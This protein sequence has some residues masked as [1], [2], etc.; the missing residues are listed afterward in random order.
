MTGKLMARLFLATLLFLVLHESV[1]AATIKRD[2]TRIPVRVDDSPVVDVKA[3]GAR[4]DGS[5][6][7]TRGIAAALAAAARVRGS[8]LRF[9]N[10]AGPC[11]SG[12]F[13]VPAGV[14]VRFDEGAL[15]SL[16]KGALA[17]FGGPIEAGPSEHFTGA[18]RV[19]FAGNKLVREAYL[20][21]W[22][23]NND[24]KTDDA[25]NLQKVASAM[26]SGMSLTWPARTN[27]LI[28]GKVTFAH[29]KN[30]RM[31][32][33]NKVG[34]DTVNA[35]KITLG[36]AG[37]IIWDC[38]RK[39]SF[40][41]L[42]VLSTGNTYALQ[43]DQ[44]TSTGGGDLSSDNTIEGNN[45]TTIAGNADYVALRI[46]NASSANNEF[47][48]ILNNT[49]RGRTQ[50]YGSR[51]GTGIY[52][53]HSNVKNVVIETNIFAGLSRSINS[54]SASFRAKTNRHSGV[55]VCYYGAFSDA[56]LIAGDDAEGVSQVLDA[57]GFGTVP[58]LLMGGRYNDIYGGASSN[59]PSATTAPVFNVQ[60][61]LYL[62]VMSCQFAPVGGNAFGPNFI[63]DAVGNN[64]PLMW[65]NNFVV[66]I[67]AEN[68]ALALSSFRSANGF[69]A[70][71]AQAGSIAWPELDTI[72]STGIQ[73]PMMRVYADRVQVGAGEISLLGLATPA[74]FA[75]AQV[76]ATG[77]T[78]RLFRIV[79]RDAEGNR[80]PDSNEYNLTNS[81]AALSVS[82]YV[83]T[84]WSPVPGASGYDLIERDLRT[85]LFRLVAALY[86]KS[87]GGASNTSPIVITAPA[88]GLHTG[89]QVYISGVAGNASANNSAANPRWSVTVTSADAFSLDASS[90][91]GAY[92]GGGTVNP[93]SYRITANPAGPLTYALPI[94]N[95]TGGAQINGPVVQGIVVTFADG[96]TT[97]SVARSSDFRTANAAPTLI[98]NFSGGRDGQMIT[99][100]MDANT[101]IQNNGS[102]KTRSGSNIVGAVNTTHSFKRFGGVWYQVD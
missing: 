21:W 24:G 8:V 81:N 101:S 7:D 86:V 59:G 71:P 16:N 68:L 43:L 1:A 82:N 90:G 96:A 11:V 78:Q 84:T 3:Y 15:L 89:D 70:S 54:S 76:G 51:T 62:S 55:D 63:R 32:G 85:G 52:L 48:Q 12:S 44:L 17:S 65:Q 61:S 53:G 42:F 87:I 4:C 10:T 5:A 99:I 45:F 66:G 19:S 72:L 47:H 98:T 57:Q 100:L 31:G 14:T 58:V 49:F 80:T 60:N 9:S 30:F 50:T 26:E 35:A 95:E 40:E 88:H 38:V 18:G 20:N 75:A 77:T 92:L 64:M 74:N 91:S 37:T 102:I 22:Q 69:S 94:Y 83:Q 28:N 34:D 6:D 73:R 29:L 46:A 67:T 23:L 33:P 36:P 79:A 39:S 27:L 25:A 56:V 41:N 13:S 93:A 97:P 2:R